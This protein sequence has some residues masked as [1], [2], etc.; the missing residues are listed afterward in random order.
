MKEQPQ[1]Q[2]KQLE[3]LDALKILDAL[4]EPRRDMTK[5]D[6]N[7]AGQ[8]LNR[9]GELIEETNAL[10]EELEKVNKELDKLKNGKPKS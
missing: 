8:A 4:T 2:T 1:P 9:F 7:A 10:V 6:C 5:Q 3:P